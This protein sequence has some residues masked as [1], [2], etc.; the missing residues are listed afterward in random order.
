MTEPLLLRPWEVAERLGVSV[1]T[2][3]RLMTDG[4]LPFVRIGQDR[5][6]PTAA[7]ADFVKRATRTAGK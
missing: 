1:T 4:E 7:V 5:R 2:V 6:I 3:K